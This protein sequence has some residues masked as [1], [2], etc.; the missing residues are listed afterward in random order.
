MMDHHTLLLYI[1]LLFVAWPI[2]KEIGSAVFG[3]ATVGIIYLVKRIR[4]F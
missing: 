1:I 4:K 3:L 2:V